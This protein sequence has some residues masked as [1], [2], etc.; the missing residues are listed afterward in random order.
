MMVSL[1]AMRPEAQRLSPLSCVIIEKSN[2]VYRCDLRQTLPRTKVTSA[3]SRV[4]VL[5]MQ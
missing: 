5:G 4:R 3:L 1:R 2:N